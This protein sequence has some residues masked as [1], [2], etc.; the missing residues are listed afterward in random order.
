MAVK[1]NPVLPAKQWQHDW[2][3]GA[4]FYEIFVRSFQDSDG[5]GIGDLN[6]LISKLDYLNDGKPETTQDLGVDAIWLMPVFASPSYHGYDTTDYRKINPQYGTNEDFQRLCQEAHKRN[7][8]VIVDLVMNH[9]SS[10]H[11][12]FQNSASSTSSEKRQWY[13][14]RKDNPGWTPPWGGTAPTWHSSNGFFY[15]GVF[16]SG[17]PDM[18]FNTAA[19]RKEFKDIAAFWLNKGLDGFRLDA[20]RYLIETGAGPAQADTEQTHQYLKELSAQVRDTKPQATLV[21]ENWTETPIIAKYFGSTNT[22]QWG[23]ELPMNFNF[24]MSE[25]ILNSLKGGN[26]QSIAA[27][28]LDVRSLYPSGVNDAPFLTNHDQIR[29]ATQFQ[30]RQPL[31]RSAASILLTLPGAPFLYYGEEVGIQNGPSQKDEDKRTPMPWDNLAGGGF[32]SASSPWYPFAPGRESAN[33]ATQTQNPKSLLSHYRNLIG[34]RKASDALM[35]GSI[36][37]LSSNSSPSP[38][39]AYLRHSSSQLVLVVHNVGDTFASAGPFTINAIS[40]RRLFSDGV[41]TDPSGSS[42]QWNLSLPPHST[43]IWEMK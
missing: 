41:F 14:W 12:W 34:I 35:H 9:S 11:P 43:G 3:R 16:W 32:T 2:S 39:L 5:D 4:V 22:I 25:R 13:V 38:V 30:N 27:K 10:E 33:V 1:Q 26:T 23:D 28:I 6:G 17:M 36:E 29:I 42:G 37:L 18:N 40:A 21:G 7:I 24:P 20:T 19:V 15:Y 8:K 31:L